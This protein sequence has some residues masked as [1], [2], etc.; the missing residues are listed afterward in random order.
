MHSQR[1]NSSVGRARPCQ[2]RGR[3]F[4]SRFPLK[5]RQDSLQV[6][7]SVFLGSTSLSDSR[8]RKPLLRRGLGR[9]R[10]QFAS[11]TRAQRGFRVSFSAPL[12]HLKS[13]IRYEYCDDLLHYELYLLHNAINILF[14][15]AK[16]QYYGTSI[17]D[18]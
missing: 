2:G 15:H 6:V 1:G 5:D 14:L 10:N 4:E 9:V 11:I 12:S 13:R 18:R 8:P 16:Q 17:N 3:E 7:L